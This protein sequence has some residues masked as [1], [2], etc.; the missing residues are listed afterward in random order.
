VTGVARLVRRAGQVTRLSAVLRPWVTGKWTTCKH[1]PEL[2]TDP[3]PEAGA[4]DWGSTREP[5]ASIR[6]RGC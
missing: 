3:R 5:T 2:V 4:I 1:R 6:V